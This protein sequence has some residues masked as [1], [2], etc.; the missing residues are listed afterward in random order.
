MMVLFC[1]WV[2]PFRNTLQPGSVLSGRTR[3]NR[4]PKKLSQRALR[5]N[6][7]LPTRCVGMEYVVTPQKER[8]VTLLRG[9]A[10]VQ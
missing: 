2:I 3:E 8:C 10:A 6:R 7:G 5:E 9:S 4:P 1:F